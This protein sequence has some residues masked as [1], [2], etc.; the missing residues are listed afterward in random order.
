MARQ[1]KPISGGHIV[2]VISMR[3][4][5]IITQIVINILPITLSVE[6]MVFLAL[7]RKIQIHRIEI[8]RFQTIFGRVIWKKMTLD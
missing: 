5:L 3:Q 7:D 1:L 6:S 4:I 8:S 2:G